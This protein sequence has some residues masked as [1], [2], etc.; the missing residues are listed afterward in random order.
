M[1]PVFTT[2]NKEIQGVNVICKKVYQGM[3]WFCFLIF[4]IMSSDTYT[5]DAFPFEIINQNFTT[6]VLILHLNFF[7]FTFLN[8]ILCKSCCKFR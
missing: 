5:E 8:S 2:F 6:L 7:S 3:N 4:L 1:L